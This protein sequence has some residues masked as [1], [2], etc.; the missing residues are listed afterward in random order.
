MFIRN[1]FAL[2]LTHFHRNASIQSNIY[3][4]VFPSQIRALLYSSSPTFPAEYNSSFAIHNT[5][6]HTDTHTVTKN[7]CAPN[8][9]ADRAYAD[10]STSNSPIRIRMRSYLRLCASIF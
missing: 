4:F 3:F 10:R 7:N 6:E 1:Y 2:T 5:T 8:A 9:Y